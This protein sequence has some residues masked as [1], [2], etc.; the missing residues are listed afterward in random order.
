MG[1]HGSVGHIMNRAEKAT[2]DGEILDDFKYHMSQALVYCFL[3]S[4][5]GQD[6]LHPPSRLIDCS[7]QEALGT[8]FPDCAAQTC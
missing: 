6:F 2:V 5:G 8:C 4:E 1:L 7:Y 3:G